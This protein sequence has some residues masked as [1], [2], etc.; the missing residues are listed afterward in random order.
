MDNFDKFVRKHCCKLSDG[1][2][3]RTG[4]KTKGQMFDALGHYKSESLQKDFGGVAMS[5]KTLNSLALKILQPELEPIQTTSISLPTNYAHRPQPLIRP[6][7]PSEAQLSVIRDGVDNLVDLEENIVELN[8]EYEAVKAAR[9]SQ[10][11]GSAGTPPS[12]TEMRL[13]DQIQDLRR[14]LADQRARNRVEQNVLA[15]REM[16][17][18]E[19]VERAVRAGER[20]V[21]RQTRRTERAKDIAIRNLKPEKIIDFIK[22]NWSDGIK[23]SKKMEQ[24]PQNERITQSALKRMAGRTAFLLDD[25]GISVD[26]IFNDIP[27]LNQ[28]FESRATSPEPTEPEPTEPTESFGSDIEVEVETRMREPSPP[29]EPA[30]EPPSPRRLTPEQERLLAYSQGFESGRTD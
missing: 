3:I 24:L 14:Q 29:P 27:G 6:V 21:E 28:L 22:R 30:V 8:Q 25:L 15:E 7:I 26:F 2:Q 20:S 9:E 4:F 23:I 13:E 18:L 17:A 19:D 10:A 11:G 1:D 12:E 16:D 5:R